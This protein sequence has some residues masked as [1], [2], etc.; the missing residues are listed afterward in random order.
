MLW[1]NPI[2]YMYNIIQRK[3]AKMVGIFSKQNACNCWYFRVIKKLEKTFDFDI[4]S[5]GP[6]CASWPLENIGMREQS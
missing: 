5:P 6:L 1:E 2:V 3:F 4:K